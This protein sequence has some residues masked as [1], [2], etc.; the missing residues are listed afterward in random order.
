[1]KLAG[2]VLKLQNMEIIGDNIQYLFI[3]LVSSDK[4]LFHVISLD[5][6]LIKSYINKSLKLVGHSQNALYFFEQ[7]EGFNN[8]DFIY[9]YEYGYK[10]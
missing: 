6:K 7:D 10:I 9:M 2:K 4:K 1:M 8:K 5:G 3:N